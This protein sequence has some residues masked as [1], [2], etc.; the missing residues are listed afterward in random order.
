MLFNCESASTS[1]LLVMP[2]H[3]CLNCNSNVPG[4]DHLCLVVRHLCLSSEKD[5]RTPHAVDA[6][7]VRTCPAATNS[8]DNVRAP[9]SLNSNYSLFSG[10]SK[11]PCRPYL[12]YLR[13]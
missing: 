9:S 8:K 1:T 7:L 4:N 6:H 10:R 2:A 13:P 11:M 3:S 5:S 12:Q